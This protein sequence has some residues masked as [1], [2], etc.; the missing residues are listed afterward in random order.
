[1]G[2]SLRP[3]GCHPALRRAG[4]H[5]HRWRR[6]V[7]LEHRT[8]TLRDAWH[9]QRAHRAWGAL[10]KL[11]GDA[12][13]DPEKTRRPRLLQRVYLARHASL[14]TGPG[15]STT[16]A[17]IITRIES[18][19]MGDTARRRFC[20]ACWDAPTR[21]RSSLACCMPPNLP[22]RSMPMATSA[23]KTGA[24]LAK[25]ASQASRS[26][27]GC[28]DQPTQDRLSGHGALRVCTPVVA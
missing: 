11:C 17:S 15:G 24:S 22:A 7:L 16:T 27:S 25:M 23:S 12:V 18:G 2:L 28:S 19:R 26:L 20:V 13:L 6:T 9:P 1:M 5:C 8:R 3:G 14:P 10:A 4:S 21:K